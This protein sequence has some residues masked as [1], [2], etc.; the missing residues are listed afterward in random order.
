[1]GKESEKVWIYVYT[2]G[3]LCTQHYVNYNPVTLKK[4]VLT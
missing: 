1:M 2:T 3:S 4:I